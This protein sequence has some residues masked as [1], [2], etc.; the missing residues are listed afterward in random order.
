MPTFVDGDTVHAY[1][2]RQTGLVWDAAPEFFEEDARLDW[3]DA[4]RYCAN[5]RSEPWNGQKG[6]RLPSM[7]ELA[8]MVDTTSTLCADGGPCLPDG[9]PFG[10]H[11]HRAL[12]WSAS[13]SADFSGDA[14]NVTFDD[15]HPASRRCPLDG[16]PGRGRR[17]VSRRYYRSGD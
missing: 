5:T 7:A 3:D 12:Y 1:C 11:V 16:H 2:D 4:R 9:Q 8:S 13:T 15:G 17:H 14:W 6:G 10:D